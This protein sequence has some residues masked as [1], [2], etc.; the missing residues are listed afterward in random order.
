MADNRTGLVYDPVYKEHV[1][2]FGHPECPDRLEAVRQGID[3]AVPKEKLVAVTPRD[4]TDAELAI[5]HTD[6]YVARVKHDITGGCGTLS[7]GDTDICPRSLAAAVRA[8]GGAMA[9][10]DAVFAGTVRNAFCAVR[11]P[12]HHATPDR[13][14]GFCIFN[15]VAIAA[16]HA[17]KT[18]G[19]ERVLIVDWDVHHGNGTQDIFYDDPSVFYFSTHQWP[20]YPMTGL[21]NERGVGKGEGFTLNCPVPAGA[22]RKEILGAFQ[23]A[24][25]PAMRS[26]KPEF[27]L[28]SAGF[29]AREAD[30]VGNL[31]LKD[32]DFADLTD[33]MLQIAADSAK[34]RIVSVLE[35]GY[36][37]PGLA[38]ATGAHVRRLAGA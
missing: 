3:D 35:G 15:N 36:W 9:A 10:V 21:P 30:L 17:Q 8:A 29:D 27:V 16:R 2:G 38:T 24:L 34:D 14:M 6:E 26:F 12:G 13:G 4:A 25:L 19:V 37:L 28:I 32:Q 5:C 33:I 18:H 11:P 20:A 31:R 1:P 22:G 7:T 23:E